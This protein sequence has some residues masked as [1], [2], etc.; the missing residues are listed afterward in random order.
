MHEKNSIIEEFTLSHSD[1][2]KAI[3]NAICT[4][5]PDVPLLLCWN[6]LFRDVRLWCHKHGASSSDITVYIADMKSLFHAKSVTEYD[7]LLQKFKRD[8][9][10]LFEEYFRKKFMDT[11]TIRLVAG[12]WRLIKCTI[13]TVE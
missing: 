6:H 13:L 3:I 11:Y 1:K 7:T 10:A 12:F 2:E 8:W 4:E 9:E 5:L